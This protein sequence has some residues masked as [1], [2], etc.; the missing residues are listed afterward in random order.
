MVACFIKES[1]GL[2]PGKKEVAILWSSLKGIPTFPRV[3]LQGIPLRPNSEKPEKDPSQFWQEK[4]KGN[5]S[6]I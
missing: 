5:H 3:L 4:G 2:S 6:E 1:K